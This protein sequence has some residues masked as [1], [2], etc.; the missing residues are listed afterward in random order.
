M[1]RLLAAKQDSFG[2]LP[3]VVELQEQSRTPASNASRTL[4]GNGT[5]AFN[6]LLSKARAQIDQPVINSLSKFVESNHNEDIFPA[7]K[8][9]S[10]SQS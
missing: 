2:G 7:E 5:G 6:D 3:D 8:S 4:N 10:I 9:R 1:N